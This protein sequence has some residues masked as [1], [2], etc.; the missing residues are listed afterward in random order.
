MVGLMLNEYKNYKNNK[1]GDAAVCKKIQLSPENTFMRFC[2]Q[3]TMYNSTKLSIFH[4][5]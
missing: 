5:K 1:K 4:L 3:C 2:S